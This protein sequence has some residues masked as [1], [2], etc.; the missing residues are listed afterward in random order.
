MNI[1]ISRMLYPVR[2]LGPG[3]RAGIWVQGCTIGCSGCLAQDTWPRRPDLAVPVEDILDWLRG[4]PDPIDGVTIS[5]G[6]PLQQPGP[7]TRLLEGIRQIRFDR[8][9]D[10]LLF[11]GYAW[12]RAQRCQELLSHCDAVVAGPYVER[13]NVGETPL[14]GSDNQRIVPLTDLGRRLYGPEAALT[15]RALQATLVDGRMWMAGIPRSGDLRHL[16]DRLAARGVTMEGT[17]WP[18]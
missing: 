17:S 18:S 7:V 15:P 13:R 2:V 6:E 10:V 3:V 8:P 9:I 4:L 14:R 12:S 16:T 1:E 11:T 5:G